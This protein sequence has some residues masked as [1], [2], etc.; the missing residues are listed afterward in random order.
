M[1]HIEEEFL[2]IEKERGWNKIFTVSLIYFI[3]NNFINFF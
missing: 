1:S 3:E 2:K